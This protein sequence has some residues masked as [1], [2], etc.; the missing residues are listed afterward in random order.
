MTAPVPSS[1]PTVFEGGAKREVVSEACEMICPTALFQVAAIYSEGELRYGRWNWAHGMPTWTIF[2][3]LF[4]H[5]LLWK[6]GDRTESHLAK[7]LWGVCTLIHYESECEC[8]KVF[9]GGQLP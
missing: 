4:R 9:D 8:H 3:H 5:L 6:R 2:R 7:V 1:S